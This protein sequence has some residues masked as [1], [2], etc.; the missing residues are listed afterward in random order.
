MSYQKGSMLQRSIKIKN[1][2]IANHMGIYIGENEVI[3]FGYPMDDKIIKTSLKEFS[4]GE[5]ITVKQYP[6]NDV[7]AEKICK[8]AE[9][10]LEAPKNTYNKKYNIFLNNCEDFSRECYGNDSH[11]VM[12]QWESIRGNLGEKSTKTSAHL[13]NSAAT[14]ARELGTSPA[15]K[16]LISKSAG[17]STRRAIK[18]GVKAVYNSSVGKKAIESIAKN[19]LGKS[20]YGGAAI[21]NVSKVARGN[22]VVGTITTVAL[23]GP[24]LYR[25]MFDKSVSWKQVSKNFASN[26]AMV[27]GGMGGWAGGAALGTAIFPGVGTIVGGLVGSIAAGTVAEKVSKKAMD[28]LHEDDSQQ[29]LSLVQEE[30]VKLCDEFQLTEEE[31]KKQLMPEIEKMVDEKWL[32]EVYKSGSCD[33]ERTEF[34]NSQCYGICSELKNK[35]PKD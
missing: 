22:V 2:K 6:D 5:I 35:M 19:A 25:A 28:Y 33:A 30:L 23:T 34:I 14:I 4:D 20:V 32:R 13:L 16:N 7:H 21:N 31:F 1:I 10:L 24:D 9:V 8:I 11:L 27:A 17:I 18:G 3:H 12:D 29:M 26:G 15:A